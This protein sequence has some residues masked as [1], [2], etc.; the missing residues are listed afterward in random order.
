ML[1][2]VA[3]VLLLLTFLA[4]PAQAAQRAQ[5]AEPWFCQKMRA[6]I[7]AYGD[8]EALAFAKRL[9]Y[10]AKEYYQAKRDCKA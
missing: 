8:A 10:T 2:H 3:S 7:A 5:V 9:N 6:G 1:A 4:S